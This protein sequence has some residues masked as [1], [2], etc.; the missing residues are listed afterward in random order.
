MLQTLVEQVVTQD[1]QYAPFTL[2]GLE[3]RYAGKL[4]PRPFYLSNGKKIALGGTIDRI[5]QQ[6]NIIR[7]IDYKTGTFTRKVDSIA[8]LFDPTNPARNR[9][10]FQLFYYAWL[11]T[12]QHNLAE[13]TSIMPTV[14]T[15]RN[16]WYPSQEVSFCFPPNDDGHTTVYDMAPYLFPFEQRLRKVMDDI[17]NPSTP[18]RRTVQAH[19]P[20]AACQEV[21]F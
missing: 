20:H 3:A 13:S 15:T 6:D 10:A 17:F 18:F 7:I 21:F 1:A 2:L 19:A 14:I 16:A 9:T 8:S 12:K 5:D 11:Y 4:S